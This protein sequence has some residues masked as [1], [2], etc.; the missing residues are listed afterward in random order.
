MRLGFP[1]AGVV[2]GLLCALAAA[3]P[4]SAQARAGG[5][6]IVNSYTTGL[7]RYGV[8]AAGPDG[9]FVI[10]WTSYDQDGGGG[11]VFGRRFDRNGTA[12]GAEFRVNTDTTSDQT[13]ATIGADA[14]GNFVVAWRSFPQDGSNIGVF[15]QRYSAAGTAL[16]AEFQVNSFTTGYQ[17]YPAVAVGAAGAFVVAWV[18]ADGSGDGIF[19]QRY[20]ASGDRLG[21][22]FLVNSDTAGNAGA[23]AAAI[24]DSGFVVAWTGYGAGDPSS[25][26]VFARR[27]DD[28]GNPLG[29]QFL[30][31]TTTFDRQLAPSISAPA[32]DG[33]FV[34]TW[35]GRDASL[36]G[37]FAQRFDAAGTPRGGEFKLDTFDTNQI[38]PAVAIDRRGSF[39]VIWNADSQ[40]GDGGAVIGRKFN[41]AGLPRGPEF[42]VNTYTTYNQSL[43]RRP[44]AIASD[45]W[46]NFVVTWNGP[47]DGSIYGILAQRFGGLRPADLRVDAA[48]GPQ[49]NGNSVFEPSERVVVN[50][51]W[52]N[53]N[54]GPLTVAGVLSGFTGPA[55]ATY[56]IDDGNAAYGTVANA[57]ISACSSDCYALRVS[58]PPTRPALHW[59]G[60]VDETLTPEQEHGQ[61]HR[62][63]LHVGASF[64]DV[65]L[66]NPFYRF[67]ETLLHHGVTGG[68]S[69]D[70]YCPSNATTREQMAAFVLA[71]KEGPG[72][73][74]PACTTPVFTDVPASSTF[75]RFIEELFRR[76]VVGGCAAGL[77]CPTSP[78]TRE[79]MAVFVLRTLDPA[80]DPPA[81]GTPVFSDVPASSLFCRWIEELV[82]RGVVAG[83]GGGNYCPTATVTRD[84]MGV[85]LGV[86]FGLALYGP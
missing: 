42:I 72:F 85:F 2:A 76:G 34:V 44:S 71:A 45:R 25:N 63:R 11:G 43:A 37:I 65:P 53:F 83:C 13:T 6:F 32:E 15:G 22:E 36:Y 55:G 74:P 58:N 33:G 23:P 28:A 78:V 62:W 49:S 51:G 54:G 64:A 77:Y 52:H 24:L 17:G 29:A 38:R 7:Q 79:Q 31:N 57:T 66:A 61:G 73:S 67:V 86:T 3:S 56:T 19:A 10:A 1:P 26:G 69:A 47:G 39:E 30:V 48:A 12:L 16:G 46:G 82:R 4:L 80:L 41:A 81:C 21:G 50:P 27:Y 60:T 70:S 14:Q 40:D 5:E 20:D 35:I 9:G 84:Q 8:V 18:S 59:D 75:C 68:C